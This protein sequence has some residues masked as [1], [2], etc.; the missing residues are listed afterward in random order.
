MLGG[1]ICGKVAAYVGMADL[2][3]NSRLCWSGAFVEKLQAILG[4]G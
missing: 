1:L 4:G 3:Q 2:L